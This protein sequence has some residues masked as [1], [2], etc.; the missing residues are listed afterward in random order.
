[1]TK[2]DTWL[3][4]TTKSGSLFRISL[5]NAGVANVEELKWFAKNIIFT[6]K[7]LV[8]E[9]NTS[10]GLLIIRPGEIESLLIRED[11]S[12]IPTTPEVDERSNPNQLLIDT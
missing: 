8:Q 9:Y 6:H 1:M 10:Q 5:E 3:V 2:Y 4:I 12:I 11:K 7:E